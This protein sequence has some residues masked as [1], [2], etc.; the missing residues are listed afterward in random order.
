MNGPP[1]LFLSVMPRFF[2][3]LFLTLTVIGCQS[4]AAPQPTPV[5]SP[6]ST[7]MATPSPT[8]TSTPTVTATPVPPTPTLTP[9]P[10]AP[11]PTPTVA[12]L[13]PPVSKGD[14]ANGRALFLS[15]GCA[16]CHR[17]DGSGFIGPRIANTALSFRQVLNQVRHPRE[18]MP[19]FSDTIVNDQQVLDIYTYLKSLP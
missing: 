10:Q 18:A 14:P 3:L 9:L 17:T 15:L 12:D 13:P 6:T 4:S 19:A 8:Q 1:H 2:Q 5:P 16:S 11:T 7:A